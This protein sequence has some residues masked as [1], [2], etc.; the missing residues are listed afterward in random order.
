MRRLLVFAAGT[1]LVIVLAAAVTVWRDSSLQSQNKPHRVFPGL[2]DAINAVEEVRIEGEHGTFSLIR[3]EGTNWVLPEL[4]DYPVEPEKV[5][6]VLV[7][8]SVLETLEPRTAAPERHGALGLNDPT[9][10]QD[11]AV[12]VSLI[13]GDGSTLAALLVGRDASGNRKARYVRRAGDDQAWLVWRNFD[14]PS[15]PMG[16]LDSSI[17]DLPRWRVRSF[18]TKHADGQEVVIERGEYTDQYFEIQ[19]IPEGF[20]AENPF[21]GNQHGT[22]LERVTTVA[23]E[24]RSDLALPQNAPVTTVETFDG[25]RLLIRTAELD[26]VDWLWMEAEYAPSIRQ[27]LPE[28]GPNVVGLP[29]MP[30]LEEAE[31]EVQDLNGRFKNWAFAIPPSKRQQFSR[32]MEDLIKEKAEETEEEAATDSLE[33]R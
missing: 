23:I 25:V 9:A 17:L 3:G 1:V 5:K 15:K 32:R 24:N 29:E 13:D 16:W 30:S 26:G 22:A 27:E 33:Q 8:L 14:L 20:E 7:S 19:G 18:V 4:A 10:T 28:D 11:G 12:A 31:Q 21:V 2:I 6:K